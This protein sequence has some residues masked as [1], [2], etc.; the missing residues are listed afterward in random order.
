MNRYPYKHIQRVLPFVYSE[1][2]AFRNIVLRNIHIPVAQHPP[3][4]SLVMSRRKSGQYGEKDKDQECIKYFPVISP[5]NDGK[6]SL[7]EIEDPGYP[8]LLIPVDP[9]IDPG[10]QPVEILS[11]LTL[12]IE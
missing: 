3:H 7:P 8:F 10:G 11:Y 12:G 5:Y 6:L 9:K 1:R 4:K 2:I